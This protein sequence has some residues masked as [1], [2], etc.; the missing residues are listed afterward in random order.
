MN[1]TYGEILLRSKKINKKSKAAAHEI[2]INTKFQVIKKC[3]NI[4]TYTKHK[5]SP[6][7]ALK[8][9]RRYIPKFQDFSFSKG[10][11]K[12]YVGSKLPIF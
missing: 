9:R 10:V 5:K 4:S 11:L 2:S 3:K 7:D 6:E 8:H 12:K 1:I